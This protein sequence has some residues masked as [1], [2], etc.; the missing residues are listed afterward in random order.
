MTTRLWNAVAWTVPV[1]TLLYGLGSYLSLWDALS[2]R[3]ALQHAY[4]RLRSPKGYPVAFI[5][6]DEPEFSTLLKWSRKHGTGPD[7]K[8]NLNQ[9]ALPTAFT[10][11]GGGEVLT[12]MPPDSPP[13]VFVPESSPIL[14]LFNYTKENHVNGRAVWCAS[15]ADLSSGITRS[16]EREQF[17]VTTLLIGL[18]S[19]LLAWREAAK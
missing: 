1:M 11:G 8:S 6:S 14:A 10:R 18:L 7:F 5:Y 3:R 2:G 12:P 19:V 4:D 9:G 13:F 16:R 15:L 17:V